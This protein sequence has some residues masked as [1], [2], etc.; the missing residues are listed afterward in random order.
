LKDR[1]IIIALSSLS[2]YELNSFSKFIHSPY[3]NSNENIIHFYNYIEKFVKNNTLD[4]LN[5]EMIWSSV[6]PD[7]PFNN[8][9]LLKLNSDLTYLL[10][11]FI[12]QKEFEKSE[13]FKANLKLE[14]VRKRNITKLYKGIIADI[15]RINKLENDQSIEFYLN[16]YLIEKNLFRLKTE[17]E[18]KNE[19]VEISSELNLKNISDNLDYFYIAEKLRQ[20]C[21]L[22]GWQKMYKLDIELSNIEFIIELAQKEQY[23]NIP[24][25]NMYYNMY[26]TYNDSNNPLHYD[27]LKNQIKNSIHLFPEHEQWEIY[28]TALSYCIN[29]VNKGDINFQQETF[30]LY[31]Q[32]IDN[33]LILHEGS[34]SATTFRN[35]VQIATRVDQSAWAE[36][37]IYEYSKHVDRKHRDNAVEFSLARLEFYRKNYGK[38]LEH[39]YR[40][41]YEDVWYNINAKTL[42][43]ACYYELDEYDALESLLQ[44]FK[45][46]IRRERS[47]TPDRKIH[48]LNLIKFTNT[49]IKIQP[50]DKK[51]LENLYTD[52]KNTK[53]VVSK[54]WLEEKIT[55]LLNKK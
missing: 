31:K 46:Y 24:A 30:E 10:E 40:V 27:N 25:I 51:R 11:L 49:L 41:T 8:Q 20:Y 39:L 6:F 14:G 34:L 50:K 52:I 23:S 29:R 48:Y 36:N 21:T 44:A 38:V 16:K 53:G 32:V 45:M 5:T 7:T 13:S 22:L 37:F 33:N 15:E 47:L 3:F 9:K 17:S 42:Q 26:L 43:I 12:T 4:S 1:K 35:I 54:P 2:V 19:K 28:V 55:F 18:K